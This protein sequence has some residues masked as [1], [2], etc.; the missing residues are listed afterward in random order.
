MEGA[1]AEIEVF[2]GCVS[3]GVDVEV[4]LISTAELFWVEVVLF[5]VVAVAALVCCCA[6]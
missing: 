2:E 1:V 5:G 4:G 3:N 6:F